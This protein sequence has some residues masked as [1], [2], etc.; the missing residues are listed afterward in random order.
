MNAAAEKTHMWQQLHT[1]N[2]CNDGF[3]VI[4]QFIH[5]LSLEYH[6]YLSCNKMKWRYVTL[7]EG[8]LFDYSSRL[9]LVTQVS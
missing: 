1:G 2:D 5:M 7:T 9:H 4:M 3:T 6:Y 8:L